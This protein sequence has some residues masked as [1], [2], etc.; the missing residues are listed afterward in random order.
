MA[1][2]LEA[3]MQ[4]I[5][6][7]QARRGLIGDAAVDA[8]LQPLQ[9]RLAEL[10]GSEQQLRQV[11]VLFIEGDGGRARAAPAVLRLGGRLLQSSG[12]IQVCAFGTPKAREDDAERAVLAALEALAAGAARAGIATGPVLL[13]GGV[14]GAGSIRG[15]T[16]N[17]AAR[18]QQT[19]PAAGLRLCPD[20]LRAVRGLF[21]IEEAA[22]LAVKGFDGAMTTGLVRGRAREARA[23]PHRGVRGV[24]PPLIGRATE[25]QALQAA[26]QARREGAA[27]ATAA[28]VVMGEAGVGKSRLCTE[29]RAWTQAEG[30]ARWL[31][32][33]ASEREMGRPYGLLR[34]L[35]MRHL[36]LPDGDSA[37]EARARWLGAVAPLLPEAADAAVLGHLLGLDFGDH[38]EVRPLL[39]DGRQLRDRGFF[40]AT[41][42]LT[43]LA[44]GGGPMALFVDDLQWADGGT[45]DFAE[46]LLRDGRAGLVMLLATARP[47]LDERL[48]GWAARPGRRMLVL[49]PLA[50]GDAGSLAD[51]LLARLPEAPAA[52]HRRLVEGAEGNPF[53]ME[54]LLN[55]LID[56]GVIAVGEDGWRLGQQALDARAM[57]R[58]LAGVLQAR[59]DALDAEAAHA[60]RM[61]AVVGPV[62]WAEAL[63]ALGIDGSE[64]LAR[65][66]QREFVV[67]R[68]AAAATG[69]TEFA[70]RHHLLHQVCYERVLKRDRVPAH[71]RIAQW[72][73]QQPG[74]PAL[75]LIAEHHERGA[76]PA[77]ALDAWQQAAEVARVRYA[78]AQAL[79]HAERALALVPEE[80]LARCFALRMQR[81]LVLSIIGNAPAIH[82]ELQALEQ[83]AETLDDN[84]RRAEAAC[85]RAAFLN[86][87]GEP[88]EA[89][90]VARQA[91]AWA[92]DSRPDLAAQAG[93]A[94][95]AALGRLGRSDEARAQAEAALVQ[96]RRTGG[97][98]MEGP[99]LNE[100]G[101]LA[102]EAGEFEAARGFYRQA[103][104]VHR[105]RGVRSNEAGTLSNLGYV[106][107]NVG[108]YA[109]AREVFLEAR[110]LFARIGQRT[111]EGV[112]LI[113]LA[114]A[115]LHGGEPVR[116][117]SEAAEATRRLQAA[118]V[119]WAE[120]AARR[121]QGQAALALGD[122][123]AAAAELQ[124][125]AQAFGA[126][127]LAHLRHEAQ[128]SLAQ[129]AL[130]EGRVADALA[131]AGEVQEALQGGM[132]LNGTEEPMRVLLACWQALSAAGDPRAAGWLADAADQLQT[133]AGRLLTPE[134]R[135]AFLHGV[136]HHRALWQ[137][138]E[139]AGFISRR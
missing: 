136:P 76:Q 58:T 56:R 13:G 74:E 93:L 81:V 87:T 36:A 73:A 79:A 97:G 106:D 64:A 139:A 23:Q 70:F 55:M 41:Q 88:A 45:L 20:T 118:G 125:A 4:A 132:S 123:A 66:A 30:G 110:D 122:T 46:Q 111:R 75:E 119:R 63:A 113:N 127:G 98:P 128:A 3:L 7:L 9:Q 96:A 50:S 117:R 40:H 86:E 67:V 120:A 62:F 51:A 19:A 59:L 115:S 137:A 121:V 92:G 131:L 11:S 116:A 37:S 83:L 133:R 18:M 54:E 71:A 39:T 68:H 130:A 44:R 95:S 69:R 99:I 10:Q 15:A 80:D 112:V 5:D 61:A 77:Q 129:V 35:F 82:A 109:A 65:L 1:E 100:L 104:Q 28:W 57:P 85:R 43:A 12:G 103:L 78:N 53:F 29:L 107:L 90:R 26:W 14:D 38:P 27:G 124:A 135:Q 84:G 48:P 94:L 126:L 33:H 32:A 114:L 34:Q 16:V 101:S 6:S 52:L 105:Q 31:Q 17:L 21:D 138:A 49:S 8:A 25:L 91:L 42:A 2:P 72:L 134:S 102:D 24:A 89:V 60:A 47:T 108:R 22:P